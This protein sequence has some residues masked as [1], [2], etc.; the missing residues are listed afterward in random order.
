MSGYNARRTPVQYLADLNTIPSPTDTSN[1]QPETYNLEDD[2]ALFTNAEFFDFDIGHNIE[3]QPP[4]AF[5]ATAEERARR[6]NASSKTTGGNGKGL[7][8][9]TGTYIGSSHM[10]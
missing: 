7:Q 3:Q 9:N 1:Q 10:P 2:L 4:G 8:I 5:D 6:E